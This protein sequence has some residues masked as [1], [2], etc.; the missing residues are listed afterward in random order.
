ME[1]QRFDSSLVQARG[2]ISRASWRGAMICHV[3]PSSH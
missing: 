3:L 2:V 1:T